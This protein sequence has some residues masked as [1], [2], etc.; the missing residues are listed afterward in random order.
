MHCLVLCCTY[1]EVLVNILFLI[2][3]LSCMRTW[4]RWVWV[5]AAP[6]EPEEGESLPNH[7]TFQSMVTRSPRRMTSPSVHGRT[8]KL[9]W[10][11]RISMIP[12]QQERC[13]EG[14]EGTARGRSLC[15][16]VWPTIRS[17]WRGRPPWPDGGLLP[18]QPPVQEVVASPVL[19]L[20]HCQLL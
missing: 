9:S 2:Q 7:A 20:P 8:L 12:Q 14:R 3:V 15:L 5:P 4:Q 16:P 19:L 10:C 6:S 17:T 18:L 13:C 1:A 11:F